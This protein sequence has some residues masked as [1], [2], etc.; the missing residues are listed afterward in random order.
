M[1]ME[2][3]ADPSPDAYGPPDPGE[4]GPPLCPPLRAPGLAAVNLP[5]QV[6]PR[7]VRRVAVDVDQLPPRPRAFA[8]AAGEALAGPD[9]AE[10]P[11]DE[12][13][14][15]LLIDRAVLVPVVADEEA[16]PLVGVG[17]R[18]ADLPCAGL[19]AALV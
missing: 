1:T 12:Q 2:P 7:A 10:D 4:G 16:A 11:L 6:R 8:P 3:A 15:V 14:E 9:R 18:L 13:V 17:D 5:H 19:G